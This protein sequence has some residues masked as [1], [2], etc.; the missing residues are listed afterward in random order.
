MGVGEDVQLLREI[1]D[2]EEVEAL[3]AL[4]NERQE[5]AATSPYIAEV[6]SKFKR[7]DSINMQNEQ[8]KQDSFGNLF[9]KKL[10]EIK[11]ERSDEIERWKQ[12]EKD[13]K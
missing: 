10:S 1:T 11:Q 3:L 6:L 8:Q 13:G 12:K 2:P 4:Y 7:K 5:F 9:E